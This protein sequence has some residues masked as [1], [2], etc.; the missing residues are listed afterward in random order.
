MKHI[1]NSYENIN[2]TAR[3]NSDCPH[4][5]LPEEIFFTISIVG[6]LENLIVLLAVF[7]NKNLQAPVYFFICS[8]AISDMLGSLYKILENILII[9]RNMGYLKPRGSFET[10][11]DDIIDSLFVLSLLGSIF[12]LSV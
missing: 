9:L 12:S 8:L 5:V 6:V 10:T 2:N 11:A 1:I 7:K 3:N 4:V